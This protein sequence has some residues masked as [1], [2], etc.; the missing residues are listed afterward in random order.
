[1]M[2]GAFNKSTI[3]CG[4]RSVCLIFLHDIPAA[5]NYEVKV[6]EKCG[7]PLFREIQK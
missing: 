5:V 4:L 7:D 1:M 2:T 6:L 3:V